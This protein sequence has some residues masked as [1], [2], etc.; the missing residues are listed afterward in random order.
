MA[1]F[2]E[3]QE[4]S[5]ISFRAKSANLADDWNLAFATKRAGHFEGFF[6]KDPEIKIS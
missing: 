6:D 1:I 4:G 2:A 3:A 5:T